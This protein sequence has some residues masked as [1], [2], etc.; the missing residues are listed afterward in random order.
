MY[1]MLGLSV[2][3]WLYNMLSEISDDFVCL[4]CQFDDKQARW[5]TQKTTTMITEGVRLQSLV[6]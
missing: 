1:C 3:H 5:L 4:D 2:H 6:L